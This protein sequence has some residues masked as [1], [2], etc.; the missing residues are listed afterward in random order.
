MRR[1]APR[2][3]QQNRSS[4]Q[5]KDPTKQGSASPSTDSRSTNLYLA[6]NS[7][8]KAHLGAI[9]PA[10]ET[11]HGLRPPCLWNLSWAA[12]QHPALNRSITIYFCMTTPKTPISAGSSSLPYGG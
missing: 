12:S 8:N 11:F 6:K 1:L 4:V 7:N 10:F 5:T 9:S 2:R 3:T